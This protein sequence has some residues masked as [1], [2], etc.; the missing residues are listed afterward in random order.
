LEPVNE[1]PKPELPFE[2]LRKRE[3]EVMVTYYK[4]IAQRLNVQLYMSWFKM[5]G[6]HFGW[7]GRV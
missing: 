1:V 7:S 3:Y 5:S 6:G 4:V 2:C